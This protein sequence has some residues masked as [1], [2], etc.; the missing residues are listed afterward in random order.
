MLTRCDVL[1]A[2]E[3]QRALAAASGGVTPELGAA[4]E[5]MNSLNAWEVD[6][7]ARRML[8]AVGLHDPNA[9]VSADTSRFEE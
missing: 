8:E 5:K 6:S 9:K 3:Y 1:G 2:Q 4:L 7:E